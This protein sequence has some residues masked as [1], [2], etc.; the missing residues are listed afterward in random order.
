MTDTQ[1]QPAKLFTVE[2]ANSMLPLVRAI[3]ADLSKLFRDLADRQTR[4]DHLTSGRERDEADVYSDELR[5]MESQLQQDR[6][7]LREYAKE[8]HDLGVECK[9]PLRGLIDFPSEMDG[10]IVYLCWKLG[11]EEV[12]HWHELD[13]GFSGR[14][15]LTAGSVAGGDG[16]ADNAGLD[17]DFSS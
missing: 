9:D 5:E 16:D 7:Q 2:Q 8:L 15:S 6:L 3:V 14:Q 13:A 17:A 11:E 12:L 4:L 10:R 1:P